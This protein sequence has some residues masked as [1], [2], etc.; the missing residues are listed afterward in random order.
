MAN[1]EPRTSAVR[2]KKHETLSILQNT[3]RNSF[4]LRLFG[5]SPEVK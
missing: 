2:T 4:R 3:L 1:D 5:L